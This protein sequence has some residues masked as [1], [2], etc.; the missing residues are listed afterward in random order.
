MTNNGW[1]AIKPNQTKKI[2]THFSKS[3]KAL[4]LKIKL[5]KTKVMSQLP[6]RYYEIGQDIWRE[7]QIQ[8]QVN[9]FKYLGSTVANNKRR[10]TKQDTQMSN[11]Y[12]MNLAQQKP[13]YKT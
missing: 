4:G 2:I 7:G 3:T 12:K 6:P 8:T 13:F 5:K 11:A 10:D 9:K 1:C